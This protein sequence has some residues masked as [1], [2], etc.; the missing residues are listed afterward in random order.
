MARSHAIDH[1]S[2]DARMVQVFGFASEAQL[3][4]LLD[5]FGFPTHSPTGRPL[6]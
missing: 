6:R 4:A 2:L 5:A 3:P 1:P